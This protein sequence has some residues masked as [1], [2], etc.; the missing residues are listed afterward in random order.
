M[1]KK[2]IYIIILLLII[3]GLVWYITSKKKDEGGEKQEPT[4]SKEEKKDDTGKEEEDNVKKD[5]TKKET[6]T[7]PSSTGKTDF[8]GYSSDAQ[9]VGES[10][11]D[12]KY[13]IESVS[14]S[15]KDGYHEFVFKLSSTDDDDD[16]PLVNASYVSS[17]GVIRVKFHNIEKD[18]TGIARQSSKAVNVDGISKIYRNVSGVEGEEIYDIGIAPTVFKLVGEEDGEGEWSI[19][20]LVKYVEQEESSSVDMGSEDFSKEDQS[21][22]G[23]GVDEKASVTS[24]TYGSAGGVLKFVWNVT[25]EGSTPIPSVK[26]GYD[27]DKLVVEF[28]GLVLDRVASAKEI[29]L[30]RGIKLVASRSGNVSTYT[31]EGVEK[32]TEFKLSASTSPNQ[33]FIEIK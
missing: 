23:A 2:T 20:L 22:T 32:D 31:F 21:I 33:V 6:T 10:S 24:Y 1:K 26:A 13:T 11:D 4:I 25:A 5:D 28:A 27:D 17:A 14:D 8:S 29:T 12:S 9:S 18:S 7:K 19:T 16:M 15:S 30:G 3:T